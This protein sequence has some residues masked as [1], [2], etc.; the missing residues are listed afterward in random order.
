MP[1]LDYSRHSPQSSP[2][3]HRHR[4][5][6]ARTGHARSMDRRALPTLTQ[7]EAFLD[8]ANA[9]VSRPKLQI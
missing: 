6:L 4:G 1:S 7:S 9:R 3:R 8:G 2:G 5:H